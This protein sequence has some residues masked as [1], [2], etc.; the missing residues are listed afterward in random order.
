M[1]CHGWQYK[2]AAPLPDRPRGGRKEA[3]RRPRG[4]Y[5]PAAERVRLSSALPIRGDGP[6]PNLENHDRLQLTPNAS[7]CVDRTHGTHG[8]RRSQARPDLRRGGGLAGRMG[9][10]PPPSPGKVESELDGG[11][12]QIRIVGKYR[13]RYMWNSTCAAYRSR[14]RWNSTGPGLDQRR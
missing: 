5:V 1:N 12:L 7:T 10:S 2:G 14:A 9:G 3:A 4:T 8:D 6:L 11:I 13:S